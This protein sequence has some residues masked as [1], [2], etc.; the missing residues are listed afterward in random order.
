MEHRIQE[1]FLTFMASMLKGYS[2]N[3]L[4][5]TQQP[6]HRVTDASARFDYP[7]KPTRVN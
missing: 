5:I 2:H 4:P 3:L 1:A 7:G 6:N